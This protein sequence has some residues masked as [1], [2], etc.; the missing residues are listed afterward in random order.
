MDF[1]FT[2]EQNLLRDSVKKFVEKSY[3]WDRRKS[4]LESEAGFSRDNWKSFAD[5]GWTALPFAEADGGIGGKAVDTMIVL[6]ELGKG[7]VLEPYISTVIFAGGILRHADE[8][9]RAKY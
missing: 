5:L 1:S 2:E 7:L 3:T 6:E 4:L 9:S 8:K